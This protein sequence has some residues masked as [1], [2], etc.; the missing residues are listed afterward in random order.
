MRRSVVADLFFTLLLST[1]L[2]GTG[3]S[4][5]CASSDTTATRAASAADRQVEAG[6]YLGDF[7]RAWELVRDTY[8]DENHNG[9]D[10]D[11]VR[12][13]LRPRAEAATTRSENRAVIQAMVEKLG[14]SH[15]GVIPEEIES[16]GSEPSDDAAPAEAGMSGDGVAGLD[17]RIVE[18]RTVVTSVTPDGPADRA[19]VRPG[20][21]IVSVDG[22]KTDELVEG[23]TDS[24]GER[25]AN[26]YAWQTVRS[27]LDGAP[28]SEVEVELLNDRNRRV[29]VT[30][31]RTEDEGQVVK[32]GN[33]PPTR[34]RLDARWL[35]PEETGDDDARV[36]YIAFN[37]FM[38]PITPHFERA[39]A[40]FEGADGLVIDLRGNVGGVAAMC[41]SL[42]RYLID[43]PARIGTMKMRGQEIQ[44]NAQPVVVTTT[45]Q[46]LAPFTGPLAILIDEGTASTSEFMAGGLRGLGRARTF[47]TRS[48]GMA[49]PA[50]M[51]RLPSGD[52]FM[53]A[54]AD[55]V[56][57]DG[58]RLESDGVP[59]D[60]DLPLRRR[61]LL[62]GEDAAL[63]AAAGWIVE[64]APVPTP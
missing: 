55:Y 42:S 25:A 52:V 31:E 35:T 57:S 34:I 20:W 7:D 30:L 24:V 64:S 14:E 23:L 36:G 26:L 32:F 56:S 51:S 62:R 60:V 50:A 39:V 37:M 22:D 63:R 13:E 61:D 45:G 46:R 1:V 58:A 18:G 43:E 4:G 19:G 47:G 11:G 28:G 38:I 59:T 8:H 2:A 48:A 44:F 29:R 53:H 21:V 33:L 3:L 5:G 12:D 10:W 6:T 41:A 17:L 27:R 54:I 49:L 40:Q 9:L 15:F 16:V